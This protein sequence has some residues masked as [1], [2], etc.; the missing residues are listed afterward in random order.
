MRPRHRLLP[1]LLLAAALLAGC[2]DDGGRQDAVSSGPP[3]KGVT[4]AD[5][6]PPSPS[7]PGRET[8]VTESRGGMQMRAAPRPC[9]P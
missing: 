5:D 4:K 1:A 2:A 3:A 6:R 7:R 9:L 8:S